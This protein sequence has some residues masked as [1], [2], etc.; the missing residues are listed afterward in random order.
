MSHLLI[1]KIVVVAVVVV[2][3]TTHIVS[4]GFPLACLEKKLSSKKLWGERC[5]RSKRRLRRRLGDCL[6][7]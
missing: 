7:L 3:F 1:I 6:P 4:G 2:L 5:V